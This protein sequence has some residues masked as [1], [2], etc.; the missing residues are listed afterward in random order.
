MSLIIAVA[1]PGKLKINRLPNG[2]FGP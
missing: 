2:A 1:D